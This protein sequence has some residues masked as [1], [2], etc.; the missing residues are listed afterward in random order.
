VVCACADAHA[1]ASCAQA[2]LEACL[3]TG[4]GAACERGR[5]GSDADADAGAPE[6][7]PAC[8]PVALLLRT[9]GECRLSDFLLAQ[10]RHRTRPR[11]CKR[12]LHAPR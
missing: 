11:F 12:E 3:H 4:G 10:A 5:S 9:S 8:P 2:L 7:A 1:R 6:P